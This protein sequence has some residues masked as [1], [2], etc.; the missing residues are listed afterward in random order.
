MD[1]EVRDR[2][3]T[4]QEIANDVRDHLGLLEHQHVGRSR[5]HGEFAIPEGPVEGELALQGDQI[6]VGGTTLRYE[7]S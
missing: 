7:E 3:R 4:R 6:V 1:R 2:L 5:D